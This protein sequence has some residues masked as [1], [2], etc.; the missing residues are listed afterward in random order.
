MPVASRLSSSALRARDAQTMV[1]EIGA[2][3]ALGPV[4]VAGGRVEDDAGGQNPFALQ[5]DGNG[6]V[7]NGVQE[8]GGAVERVDD[9]AVGLVGAFDETAFLAEESITWPGL[10]KLRADHRL[11]L[12]VGGGDKVGQALFRDL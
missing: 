10:F 1:I 11:G 9:P 8:I 7:R 6:E 2:L 4:K 3:A 12:D 5:G